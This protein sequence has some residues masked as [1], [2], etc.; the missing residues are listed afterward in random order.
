MTNFPR[1]LPMQIENT[2]EKSEA[3]LMRWAV[4]L[5]V[6][7]VGIRVLSVD[8]HLN[9][10][11]WLAWIVTVGV[12]SFLSPLSGIALS[13][14]NVFISL[15]DTSMAGVSVGQV[16]GG[17]AALRMAFQLATRRCSLDHIIRPSVVA[18]GGIMLVVLLSDAAS[19]YGVMSSP[20]RILFKIIL[21]LL[22]YIISFVYVDEP[23][24]LV[25]LQVFIVTVVALAGLYTIQQGASLTEA[26]VGASGLTGN[27]NYQAIYFAV[28]LPIIYSLFIYFKSPL[29][30]ILSFGAALPIIAGVIMTASRGGLL[31]LVLSF[32]V[33]MWIWGRRG[34]K[35]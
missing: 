21:I 11:I 28:T 5:A 30:R 25:F 6:L 26:N 16:A 31:T 33:V 15:D 3:F 29:W 20:W 10:L 27:S 9:R 23:R 12:I 1:A 13:I 17:A 2:G 22:L 7:Q 35:K 24:K 4:V 8:N 18:I 19:P 32:A 14:G 34:Q